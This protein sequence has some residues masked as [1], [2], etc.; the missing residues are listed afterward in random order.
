M[1]FIVDGV[2][3]PVQ[4]LNSFGMAGLYLS[5]LAVG[6]H[7]VL[8]AYGGDRHFVSRS[9]HSPLDFTVNPIQTSATLTSSAPT[10]AVGQSVTFTATV[11]S[12][13]PGTG[14]P[15]GAVAFA[16]DGGTPTNVPVNAA[17]QAVLTLNSLPQGS[18]SVVATY[19]ASTD[20]ATSSA[21]LTENILRASS[22]A[23]SP[24]NSSAVVGQTVSVTAPVSGSGGA[25]TRSVTFSVEGTSQPA[26]PL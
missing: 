22:T 24:L 11:G 19:V 1:Q 25:P 4:Q 12:V 20:Y 13:A 14:T 2:A 23:I 10:A 9:T 26:M 5:N 7:T 6:P 8:A 18:H 15:P 21:S 3:Q 16:I 17:G